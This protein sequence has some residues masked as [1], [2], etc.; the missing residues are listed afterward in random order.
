MEYALLRSLRVLGPGLTIMFFIDLFVKNEFG[1]ESIFW[2]LDTARLLLVGYI[3]GG[4]YS[5]ITPKS[6]IY[7]YAFR[8]VNEAIKNKL[9]ELDNGNGFS[10]SENK[11]SWENISPIFYKL[12]DNDKSLSIKAQGVFFNGFIVTTSFNAIIISALVIA[13]S[14]ISSFIIDFRYI[15]FIYPTTTILFS[16]IAW[17]AAIER[18]KRLSLE[19][20][21]VMKLRFHQELKEYLTK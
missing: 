10:I 16:I 13:T 19:Q 14:L 3:I 8:G 9:L 18:H 2:N 7:S 21:S 20:V 12:I 4:V 11:K 5:Y 15:F 6:K 1:W 17:K